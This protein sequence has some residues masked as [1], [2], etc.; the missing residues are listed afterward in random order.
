MKKRFQILNWQITVI[1]TTLLLVLVT[2]YMSKRYF[3]SKEI[4]LLTESCQQ[5]GGKIIL[6]TNRFSMDYS[7]ECQKK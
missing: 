4:E 5:V 6:E 2:L 1:M 3:Y 7:F